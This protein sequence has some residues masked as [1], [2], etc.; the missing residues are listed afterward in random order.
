MP[1]ENPNINGQS[2]VA[3]C[4]PSPFTPDEIE[5]LV[6]ATAERHGV[7]ISLATAIA[8]AESRFDHHRSSPAGARGPMQLM[9]DTAERF[10][11]TDVCDPV[12]NI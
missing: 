10:N 5:Q 1:E 7:D 9:P 11:V 8:Y 3:E 2:G 6:S 4:G 12:S